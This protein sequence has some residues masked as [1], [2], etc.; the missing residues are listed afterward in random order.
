MKEIWKEVKGYEGLYEVSNLGNVRSI[1]R[2]IKNKFYKGKI[3]ITKIDK[4]GYLQLGLSKNGTKKYFRVHRLVAQAFIPNPS[5]LPQVNHKDEVKDNNNVKNLEWCDNK[6]NSSYGTKNNRMIE[7]RNKKY[8][9]NRE[10]SIIQLTLSGEFIKEYKS[11]SDASKINK[12]SIGNLWKAL[13]G[14][15]RQ[16]SGYIWKY[17]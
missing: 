1:N 2:I 6:Y 8:L 10:K 11:L 9:K 5:N 4:D 16:L 3:L 13:N 14:K 7:T 15:I 17:N 12:L